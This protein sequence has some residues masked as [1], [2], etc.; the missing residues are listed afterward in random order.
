[1]I[2][3]SRRWNLDDRRRVPPTPPVGAELMSRMNDLTP[4]V[5]AA[6]PFFAGTQAGHRALLGM[7]RVNPPTADNALLSFMLAVLAAVAGV[8]FFIYWLAQPTVLANADFETKRTSA[9]IL[10]SSDFDIETSAIN[11]ARQENE[12]QGLRPV[13]LAAAERSLPAPPVAKVATSKP[14]VRKRVARSEPRDFGWS[15]DRRSAW[16]FEPSRGHERF[17][18]FGSWFR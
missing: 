14:S 11:L 4:R 15:P 10:R 2:G 9:I 8:G 16:A 13:A 3:E 18:G 7:S 5:P 6:G 12:R 17:G 1:M